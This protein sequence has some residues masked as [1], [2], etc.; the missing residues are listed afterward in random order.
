[1]KVWRSGDKGPEPQ[2]NS[3]YA[4]GKQGAD[5]ASQALRA[6]ANLGAFGALCG[7]CRRGRE[8]SAGQ[9]EGSKSHSTYL[10]D[11]GGAEICC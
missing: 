6:L 5:Q 11:L 2:S 10:R 8:K 3:G 9:A 7:Q 4:L 1:M